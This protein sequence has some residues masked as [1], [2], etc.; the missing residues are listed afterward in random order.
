MRI[1]LVEDEA[2]V[3]A[4]LVAKGLREHAYAVDVAGDGG[5]DALAEAG[6]NDYDLII[7]D[8]RLPGRS[9]LDVCVR[10]APRASSAPC[11]C[12]R[13]GAVDAR[14]SAAS[15]RRR[16]RDQAVRLRGTAGARARAAAARAL[17]LQ[18]TVLAVGR[19]HPRH[20]HAAGGARRPRGIALTSKEYALLEFLARRA[21]RGPGPR[22]DLRTRLGRELR[23]LLQ[24]DRGVRAAA[25]PQG[26]RR[27]RGEADPHA[28]RRR[29]RPPALGERAMID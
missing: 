11:S 27:P 3:A 24:F 2:R 5:D 28:P 6:T 21:G 9:G 25:P 4:W 7:L 23:C 13:R 10:C 20:P 16:L 8:M 29:L 26:G 15:G 18:A 17:A 19:P 14:W 22:R 1:L 12:S